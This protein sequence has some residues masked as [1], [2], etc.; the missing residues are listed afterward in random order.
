MHFE[1]FSLFKKAHAEFAER[2]ISGAVMTII[3]LVCTALVFL[4]QVIVYMAPVETA[5]MVIQ[6]HAQDMIQIKLNLDVQIPCSLLQVRVQ[7]YAGTHQVDT[8][9]NLKKVALNK[10]GLEVEGSEE[11]ETHKLTKL[12]SVDQLSPKEVKSEISDVRKMFEE[13]SGCRIDGHLMVSKVPGKIEI[14]ANFGQKKYSELFSSESGLTFNTTH[15]IRTFN[16]LNQTAK[17][18]HESTKSSGGVFNYIMSF[19]K[20]FDIMNLAPGLFGGSSPVLSILSPISVLAKVADKAFA[21]DD[22]AGTNPERIKNLIPASNFNN[23]YLEKFI[24]RWRSRNMDNPLDRTNEL[25][26]ATSS[27]SSYRYY[28]QVVPLRLANYAN[29]YKFTMTKSKFELPADGEELPTI[30]FDYSV[31]PVTIQYKTENMS[32][33]TLLGNLLSMT[34]GVYAVSILLN[35]LIDSIKALL[36]TSS[37]KVL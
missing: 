34:G 3:M 9:R 19:F 21:G 27:K 8:V 12:L 7:D 35:G 10:Y 24:G 13:Y 33:F 20:V 17:D 30:A 22:L 18:H 37:G 29:T 6:Q 1:D 28:L 26:T 2:T 4:F 5:N 15:A 32:I 31:S 25:Q 16:F 11:I 36:K 14:G 23:K